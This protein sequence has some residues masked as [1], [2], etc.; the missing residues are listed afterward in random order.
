MKTT[1]IHAGKPKTV[2]WQGKNV[3]TGI[4]KDPV[5]QPVMVRKLNIDG[6]GQ[7]D[8]TVHGGED[9]AVYA[10]PE[11]AYAWWNKELNKTLAEGFFGENLTVR[12]L[13]ESQMAI[14]DIYQ[15]GECQ[16]QVVQPRF[17]CSKLG[18]K[19][20]DMSII[21][22][23]MKSGRPGVYFRVIKEG[24]IQAGDGWKLIQSE[25]VRIP[26]TVLWDFY[27]TKKIDE[28]T[29]LNLLGLGSLNESWRKKIQDALRH[30]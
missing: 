22:T 12:G 25:P 7:A 20:G 18:V 13:D 14:G 4:Y 26:V 17:P 24:F 23:F 27:Q 8:L 30:S 28:V 1:S 9:K 11:E 3:T 21:K 6:D 5:T 29:G 19:F 2:T 16:L 15:V 10:Y